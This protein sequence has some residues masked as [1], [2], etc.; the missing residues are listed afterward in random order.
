MT[1][2]S[3]MFQTVD[4]SSVRNPLED[5]QQFRMKH[6]NW[7]AMGYSDDD[8]ASYCLHP[9]HLDACLNLFKIDPSAGEAEK[10]FAAI[11]DRNGAVGNEA[12][13][14]ARYGV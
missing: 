3:I 10:D 6:A 8:G 7:L 5:L 13:I 14:S 2:S 11:C 9:E 12:S 4:G 1:T